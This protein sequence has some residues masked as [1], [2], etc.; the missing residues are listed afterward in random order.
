MGEKDGDGKKWREMPLVVHSQHASSETCLERLWHAETS[1]NHCEPI[2]RSLRQF[3]PA[4]SKSTSMALGVK[5]F[6]AAGTHCPLSPVYFEFS[7]L[8]LWLWL[9]YFFP[10]CGPILFF[11]FCIL[12]II[13][14]AA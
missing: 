14:K 6:L 8:S 2:N 3:V 4:Q 11:G 12:S 7:W 13:S 9:P 10:Y 1:L 5:L